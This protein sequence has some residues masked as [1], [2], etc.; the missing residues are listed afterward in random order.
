MYYILQQERM[1]VNIF[2]KYI[3]PFSIPCQ[4]HIVPLFFYFLHF[5]ILNI[6]FICHFVMLIINVSIFYV[7]FL[8]YYH[9]LFNF[10]SLSLFNFRWGCRTNY[11]TSPYFTLVRSNFSSI[12]SAAIIRNKAVP[13]A[14][15]KSI[16]NPII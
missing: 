5:F 3:T 11:S 14:C 6:L 13:N 9:K 15:T 2:L 16:G 8:S 4:N 12:G 1:F 7:N 10:S